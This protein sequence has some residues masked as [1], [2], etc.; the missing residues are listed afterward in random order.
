MWSHQQLRTL[1]A[2]RPSSFCS[3]S[4]AELTKETQTKWRE[5]LFLSQS[6]SQSVTHKHKHKDTHTP[7][8]QN[9]RIHTHIHQHS[10][11]RQNLLPIPS[12]VLSPIPSCVLSPR[13]GGG[14][15]QNSGGAAALPNP[16]EGQ[17]AVLLRGL[18]PAGRR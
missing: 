13:H 5:C 9:T 10:L 1:T 7:T 6:A 18:H 4:T 2:N 3:P 12:C 14:V 15:A 16:P 11:V 8:P 17:P